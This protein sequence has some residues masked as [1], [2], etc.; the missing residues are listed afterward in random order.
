MRWELPMRLTG[1]RGLA[2][3]LTGLLFVSLLSGLVPMPTT[4][5]RNVAAQDFVAY[6]SPSLDGYIEHE[7]G[8]SN[9]AYTAYSTIDVGGWSHYQRY[10]DRG[11]VSFATASIPDDAVIQ[12]VI[13]KLRLASDASNVD[14]NIEVYKSQYVTLQASDYDNYTEYQGILMN[15][16]GA[17]VGNWY[18]IDVKI[19]S[20]SKTSNTAYC[21]KSDGD[22]GLPTTSELVRFYSG[23]SSYAP[24]LEVWYSTLGAPLSIELE[25][26]AWTHWL[27]STV[28]PTI[29]PWN[30]TYELW[31]YS[32]DTVPLSKNVTIG[33]QN[34]TWEFQGENPA[35]NYTLRVTELRLEDVYDSVTYRVY[36]TVPKINPYT[37]VHLSLYNAFTGEGFYWELMRVQICEGNTWNN[38]TATTIAKSDFFVEPESNYTIRVL[39]YFGNA[40][41]DYPFS[42][43]AQDM[44]I[45]L[46]VPIYNYKFYNQNPSFALL[47]IY[48]NLT[49]EPYSEFIPPNDYVERLLKT[50]TYRFNITFYN[51]TGVEGNTYTWV[52]DIPNPTFPGAGFV[53]VTGTTIAEVVSAVNG[54]QALVQVAVELVSPSVIWVG[55]DIPQIPSRLLSV[56][57]SAIIN[58]LYMLSASTNQLGSGTLMSFSSPIPN[59]TQDSAIARD[60]FRFNG[61]LATVTFINDTNTGLNVFNSATLPPSVAV[62]GSGAYRVD[63]DNI[64]SCSREVDFRWYRL[65][66]W[67]YYPSLNNKYEAEITVQNSLATDWL[68]AT[69]FIPFMNGSFVNNQSVVVYDMNNTVNLVEG[70]HWVQSTQGV[71]MWFDRWNASVWR[72]FRLTYN[73]VNESNLNLP[74]HIIVNRVGDDSGLTYTWQQDTF[75]FAKVSWTNDYRMTYHGSIYIDLQFSMSIDTTTVKVLNADG[76]AITDV[77]V[78]GKTVIVREVIVP[79]GDKVEFTVIFK[80]VQESNIFDME[81]ANIPIVVT[82]GFIAL[83]AF[84]LGI[85]FTQFKKGDRMAEQWGRMFIGV[86]VLALMLVIIVFIYFLGVIS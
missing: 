45:S 34:E 61:P 72:G 16:A 22:S 70:V 9:V 74:V 33:I 40:V 48:Y 26:G 52:R 23:E 66:T 63:T 29:N 11:F 59:D 32:F 28:F 78:A 24:V 39:D 82:A 80:S 44:F 77:I 38:T 64:V 49:G 54:V 75:Y 21:L 79:V 76:N 73:A 3:A 20:L 85:F 51:E 58:N 6:S 10:W 43:N 55:R 60:Y 5:S 27:N 84:I 2:V 86:A 67:K 69:L 47:R 7:V 83:T 31:E 4:F 12:R 8:G 15:T 36:F 13:L 41:V 18:S 30:L 50:G 81:F 62:S 17:V 65:F 19:S 46:A 57:N 56:P 35:C 37:T 68:N 25:P 53:I 14:F 42:A 1:A 71:Y